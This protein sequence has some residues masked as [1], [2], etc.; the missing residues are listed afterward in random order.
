MIVF[1]GAPRIKICS[2]RGL[3]VKVFSGIEIHDANLGMF[4]LISKKKT[5]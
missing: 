4:L 5:L 1:G 3:V 2:N